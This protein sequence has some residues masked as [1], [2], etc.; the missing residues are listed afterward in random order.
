MS[1]LLVGHP[2][3]LRAQAPAL[4]DGSHDFDFEF[5]A[6]HAHLRRLLHPLSSSTNWVEYDAL[7][8]VHEVWGGK[9]NLGEFKI[10]SPALKLEG[11]SLRLYNPASHQWSIRWSNAADGQVGPPMIGEFKD[12]RG[13]FFDQEEFGGRAIL[14]RFIFSD[15]SPAAFKLEQAFSADGGASWEPNWLVS[16]TRPKP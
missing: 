14:V 6:W 4:R 11:L 12:G 16:F 13:L 15:I 2:P 8:T 10:D 7:S 3:A 5:G 9:A 1:L